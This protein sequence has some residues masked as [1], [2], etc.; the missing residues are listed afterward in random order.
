MSPETLVVV[1]GVCSVG[2]EEIRMDEWGIDVVITAS[3][4]ALGAP[5]GLCVLGVSE[6]AIGVFKARKTPVPNYY[7]NWNRWLPIMNS[8]EA[9]KPSYFATPAVQSVFALH[10]SLKQIVAQGVEKRFALHK[11]ASTKVKKFI[12]DLGLTL[13]PTGLDHAANGM[14]AVYYPE[15][16]AATD[17]LPKLS[18]HGI[19]AAGGLHVEI[20]AKYF[21][22][23]H[24]GISV[25][26]PERG[27]LDATLNALKA[28]L[29]ECG[30]KPAL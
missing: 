4:K 5:P 16:I 22:I 25:T 20:A 1:D 26:E 9:R 18:A 6:R 19:V 8:Y 24:M 28:S 21:R 27:H 12:H 2:S 15:G 13:V 7:A 3:Q 23:G 14:S 11:E 17:L 30:Y 10:V 29:A